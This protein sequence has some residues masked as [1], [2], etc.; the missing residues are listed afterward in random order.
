MRKIILS[1]LLIL[2]MLLGLL[3]ATAIAGTSYDLYV[4]GTNV[5]DY[6]H[7]ISYWKADDGGAY[8]ETGTEY[9]YDFSVSFDSDA[10]SFTLT[11]NGVD[12]VA[13]YH[14]SDGI[15]SNA[16]L[17]VILTE[18]TENIITAGYPGGI[19][20]YNDLNISGEG[21]LSI[22][23][24]GTNYGIASDSGNVEIASPVTINQSGIGI[25]ANGIVT[26]DG[27]VVARGSETG[28]SANEVKIVSGSLTASRL[29]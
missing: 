6:T 9:D 25:Y 16:G 12:I 10:E 24:I 20:A 4:G 13:Q 17:N 2:C 27:P 11:L 29:P 15:Y 14:N 18:G 22:T 19:T 7:S 28:V 5:T 3:P 1:V 8:S 21:S 23:Q 26:I